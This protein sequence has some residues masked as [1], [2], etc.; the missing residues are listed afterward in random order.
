MKPN[1]AEMSDSQSGLPPDRIFVTN[2]VREMEIGAY[3]DERGT[4]QRVRFDITLEVGREGVPAGD[5]YTR[6]VN[7]EDLVEA[8]ETL[9][10]G[11]RMN[12]VETFAERLAE[13]CLVDPRARRVQVRIEKLDRLPGGAAY[14]I[15]IVRDRGSVSRE[16][17]WERGERPG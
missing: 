11:P 3:P 15:E 4:M 8:I 10:R 6:V 14:G 5:N 17:A 16:R 12:L 13:L 9:A 2:Y 7:Y 1:G